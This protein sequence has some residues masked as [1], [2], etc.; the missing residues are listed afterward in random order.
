M[1]QDDEKFDGRT[2]GPQDAPDEKE[3]TWLRLLY[4]VI[5][6]VMLQLSF[7]VIGLVTVVQFIV[8]LLN[9]GTPNPRLA[10]FGESLGI[11][12]AKA[13]R[14]LVAASEVKPWPWSELD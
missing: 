11:W 10:E 3:G 5:I 1:M 6:W 13:A 4:M 14:Y 8:T 9:G 12:M 7:S 2:H